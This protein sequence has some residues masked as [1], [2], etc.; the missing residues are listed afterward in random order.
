[1]VSQI[2]N[3][4]EWLHQAQS[5]KKYNAQHA[6]YLALTQLSGTLTIGQCLF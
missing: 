6:A 3:G 4:V 5:Y 2:Y 1:M